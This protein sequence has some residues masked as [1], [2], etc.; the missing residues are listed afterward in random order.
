MHT[1]HTHDHT[2]ARE[3]MHLTSSGKRYFIKTMSVAEAIHSHMR[4]YFIKTISVAEAIHSHMRRYFIKTISVA[5]AKCLLGYYC[6]SCVIMKLA[7]MVPV[8]LLLPACMC[9]CIFIFIFMDKTEKQI[10]GNGACWA[11]AA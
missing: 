6:L 4:R 2:A 11:S 9:M 5:E 10:P 1:Y 8:G 7:K 3:K